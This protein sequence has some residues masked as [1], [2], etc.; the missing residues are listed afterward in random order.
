[1][2]LGLLTL[3]ASSSAG[4]A[5]GRMPPKGP[6]TA[7]TQATQR[8]AAERLLGAPSSAG[9]ASEVPTVGV[10]ENFKIRDH[11]W[12]GGR[13]AD[14]DLDFF[15]H[16]GRGRFVYVGK[17]GEGRGVQIVDVTR[18]QRSRLVATA[19]LARRK[20]AYEDVA[21]ARIGRRVV[22][23]AG[24][25]DWSFSGR[26]GL[27]LFD[28]TRPSRPR[29]LSFL[30][31]PGFLGVHELDLVVR[32]GGQA[33]ALLAVPFA[34]G[35]RV[36]GEDDKGGD[37]RVVRV[38]RPRRPRTLSTW[39]IVGDSAVPIPGLEGEITRL[40]QGLGYDPSLFGHSVRAADRGRTAYASY[41]D[42][43]VLKLDIRRPSEPRLVGRTTFDVADEGNAH[44]MTPFEAGGRRYILQN[45]EDYETLS[46]VIVQS[47]ATGAKRHPGIEFQGLPTTLTET[48]P[49]SGEVHDAG[50]GCEEGDFEGASGKVALFDVSPD[51]HSGRR[52]P[53]RF[54]R[55]ARLAHAAGA[56]AVLGNFRGQARPFQFFFNLPRRPDQLAGMPGVV[57]ADI[58]GVADAIRAEPGPATVTL[59]PQT[60]S[61]GYLRVFSEASGRDA[62]GDGVVE[63]DQVGTFSDLRHVVG[64]YP[65]PRN[66]TWTIHNT[67]VLGDRAYSSWYTHGIVALDMRDPTAPTKVGQFVPPTDDE[68]FRGPAEVWGVA[69]DRDRGLV[70]A[71]DMQTGL[72]VIKPTGPAAPST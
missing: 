42:G 16:G 53:C 60:P 25:Q 51:F 18:P 19:R 29:K 8:W 55:R 43:G 54:S 22:L 62:D 68:R 37:I 48:G 5:S 72:W 41:W 17:R 59:T 57:V 67:E 7:P 56:K 26:G 39:G 4:A 69:V 15:D 23:A 12:L 44:S 20:L 30:R 6:E 38:T 2:M 71:S 47:S 14:A 21:V 27:A 9:S 49:V 50:D 35:F 58:D 63:F 61:W 3:V 28:V 66:G 34:E 46:T 24:I 11:V 70:Y 1:M 13:I 40:S 10:A 36:S 64:K 45:D 31:V 52:P 65:P 33:L 32:A